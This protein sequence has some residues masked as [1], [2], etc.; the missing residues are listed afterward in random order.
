MLLVL[1]GLLVWAPLARADGQAFGINQINDQSVSVGTSLAIQVSVT[2]SNIPPSLLNFTLTSNRPNTDAT[3]AT[4]SL[5][6]G[7]F[8]WTPAQT[9]VV[10]F[11]VTAL[12]LSTFYQTSTNF[13]VTVT[14]NVTPGSEVVIDPIPPQTV[15]EGTLL[16]FTSTAHATDNPDSPLVFSLLNPPAGASIDQQ[17]PDERGFHLDAHRSPGGHSLLH[18]PRGGY[19]AEHAGHQLPGFPGDRHPD[20]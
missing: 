16:T 19:R 18:H 13:T 9:E 11:T 4:I 15:A 17:Q 6:Y 3:N 20:Q 10:T 7:V 5:N 1:G 14:N 12:S 8:T 2:D